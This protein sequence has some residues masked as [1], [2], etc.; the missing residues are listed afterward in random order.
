MLVS[1]RATLE[2]V[3]QSE[4]L[5][6]TQDRKLLILNGEMSEWLKEHAWKLT[7]AARAEAYQIP[8]TH[9]RINDFRNIDARCSVPVNHR[10]A[11][12]FRGVCDT[13]LTQNGS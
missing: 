11:P 2:D 8:P 5:G 1:D 4:D 3:S 10:V 12:G 6:P 9:F 13:V 7:P